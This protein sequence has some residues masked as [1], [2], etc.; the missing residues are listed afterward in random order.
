MIKVYGIKNCNTMKKAFDWLEKNK[1]A[2]TFHDYKKEGIDEESLTTWLKKIPLDKLI[3]TKG[4]T[5]RLLTDKEKNGVD[6]QEKGVKLMMEKTSVIKRPFVVLSKG[7]YVLG[8]DEE[9]WKE[10]F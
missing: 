7:N 6:S 8:F 4:A 9:E 1:V 5:W 3:N 10:K 2:Y